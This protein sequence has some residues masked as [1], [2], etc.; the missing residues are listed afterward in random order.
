MPDFKLRGIIIITKLLMSDESKLICLKVLHTLI[1]L[2]FNVVI[3]YLLYA[4]LFGELD[5]WFKIGWALLLTEGLV[6]LM[7]RLTCPITILARK[8]TDDDQ[9]NF[10]IYLPVWLA[11]YT[12]L[13][14]TGISV[15]IAVL[16]LLRLRG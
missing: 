2:F 8:Y 14:Y 7:F 10:D 12:K 3:F 16:T 15:I 4:V 13:I 5:I 1:W 6:L 9:D 11:K